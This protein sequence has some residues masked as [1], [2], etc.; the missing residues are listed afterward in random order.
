MNSTAIRVYAVSGIVL[1]AFAVSYLLQVA[2]EPPDVEKP[3][4]S[5][6]RL[7]VPVRCLARRGHRNGSRRLSLPPAPT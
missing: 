1:V 4:W 7:A 3:D 6:D 5:L 2:N